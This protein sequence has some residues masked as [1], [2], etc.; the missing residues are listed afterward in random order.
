MV[1]IFIRD[2]ILIIFQTL[3]TKKSN[4]CFTEGGVKFGNKAE[5]KNRPI[6]MIGL[7]LPVVIFVL[8]YAVR[9]S[10]M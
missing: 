5:L 3:K 9:Q 4:L 10:E 7:G 2:N 8:G 6:L 1:L